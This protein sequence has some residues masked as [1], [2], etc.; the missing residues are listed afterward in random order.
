MLGGWGG[1]QPQGWWKETT[2]CRWVYGYG[3]LQ[4]DYSGLGSAPEPT[5]GCLL[6]RIKL[7]N[8][9]INNDYT[10]VRQKLLMWRNFQKIPLM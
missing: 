2:A 7:D 1:G 9:H 5:N 10:K 3:H 8:A 4:A 6:R